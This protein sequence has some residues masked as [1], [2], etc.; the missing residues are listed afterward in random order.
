MR[1]A[2]HREGPLLPRP[3]WCLVR[4][5]QRAAPCSSTF[6][7]RLR[8]TRLRTRLD[9]VFEGLQLGPAQHLCFYEAAHELLDR[10]VAQP[11]DNLSD[12]ARREAAGPFNRAVDIGA[13]FDIVLE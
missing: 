5:I 6:L 4:P 10:P 7:R 2:T 12:G 9:A 13:S 8:C 11:V 3:A 1:V